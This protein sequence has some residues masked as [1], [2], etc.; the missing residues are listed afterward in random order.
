MFLNCFVGEDFWKSLGVDLLFSRSVVFHSFWPHRLQHTRLSG[1]S[2]S[3]RAC[4]NS[5][6][7]SQWCH[8]TISPSVLPFSSCLQS[9]SAS[10]SF[11]I[12][13]YFTLVQFSSVAQ[14]CSTL[15]DPLNHSMPGL[16]VHH[17]LPESTQTHVHRVG[18]AIQ[19][20]HPLSP[21]PPALNRSQ[22]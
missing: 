9:F 6:P 19:L 22:H 18:D 16:P 1:P 14:S 8:P 2:P 5:C 3:P 17:Q 20:S 13:R 4:S 10:G 21:S 11:L 7:Y 12:S 15:W